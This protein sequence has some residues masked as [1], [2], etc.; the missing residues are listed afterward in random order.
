MP[1][2]SPSPFVRLQNYNLP[3]SLVIIEKFD[4]IVGEAVEEQELSYLMVLISNNSELCVISEKAMAPHSS[5]FAWKIPWME[6]PGRLQSI[7]SPR[8]GHD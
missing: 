6:G 2:P 7:G 8:V 5:T 1:L 4:L 3:T